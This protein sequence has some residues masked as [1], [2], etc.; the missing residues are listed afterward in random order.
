MSG[1]TSFPL[2]HVPV[3]ASLPSRA[4]KRAASLMTPISFPAGKVLCREGAVGLEAFLL[5]SGSASVTRDGEL[6]AKLGPG[7]LVGEG[8]LIGSGYRNATVVTDEPVTALVMSR[9]EF[10]SLRALP[11]VA[12]AIDKVAAAR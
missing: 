6:L 5:V 10:S 4:L 2:R 3:L 7:D 11:G 8:A 12:G 9:R 1:K